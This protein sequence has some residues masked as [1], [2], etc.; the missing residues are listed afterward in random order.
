MLKYW[1]NIDHKQFNIQHKQGEIKWGQRMI[2]RFW[3][4]FFWVSDISGRVSAAISSFGMRRVPPSG[5]EEVWSA[6]TANPASV[7]SAEGSVVDLSSDSKTLTE[8]QHVLV[9]LTRLVSVTVLVQI[10][11]ILQRSWLGER[12]GSVTLWCPLLTSTNVW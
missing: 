6:E 11:V 3:F 9:L 7:T 1:T 5:W 12:S 8:F 2:F 4:S 10:F